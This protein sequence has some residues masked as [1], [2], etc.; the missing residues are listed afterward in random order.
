M[1]VVPTAVAKRTT[2]LGMPVVLTASV[3]ICDTV[4]FLPLTSPSPM[5]NSAVLIVA[6]AR[7]VA[8]VQAA[9]LAGVVV[10]RTI[11]FTF[12]LMYEHACNKMSVEQNF[13]IVVTSGVFAPRC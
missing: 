6:P 11:R 13:G 10:I 4:T 5:V 8:A 12:V 2:W 3:A 1:P 7:Q 9:R